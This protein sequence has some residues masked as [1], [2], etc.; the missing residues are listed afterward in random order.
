MS[1]MSDIDSFDIPDL[2]IPTPVQQDALRA[3]L[4]AHPNTGIGTFDAGGTYS[5]PNTPGGHRMNVAPDGSSFVEHVDHLPSDCV[6]TVQSGWSRQ[7]FQE[8]SDRIEMEQGTPARTPEDI[9]QAINPGIPVPMEVEPPR[10]QTLAEFKLQ[11]AKA[12]AIEANERGWC[13]DFNDLM[14]NNGFTQREIEEARHPSYTHRIVLDIVSE[15]E[16]GEVVA[17]MVEA[18]I[19]TMSYVRRSGVRRFT[20]ASGDAIPE[21]G[22]ER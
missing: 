14:V 8:A 15:Q 11:A 6:P 17:A 12:F 22:Y 2:P 4:D 5:T 20:T 9:A 13:R 19:E 10:P 16:S 3:W 21:G 7:T 18:R 1:N